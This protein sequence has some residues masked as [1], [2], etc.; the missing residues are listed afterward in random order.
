MQPTLVCVLDMDETI[1]TFQHDAFQI[2]PYANSLIALLRLLDVQLV[3]WSLG[4][5]EYVQ[6]IVN[7]HLPLVKEYAYKI[8]ARK[9][10]ERSRQRYD[11]CKASEHIRVMFESEIFLIAIDDKVSQNM[12]SQYDLR[13]N[14]LPYK[15]PDPRDR[16][17]L[18]VINKLILELVRLKQDLPAPSDDEAF[19]EHSWVC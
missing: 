6:R 10:C 2:R 11:F 14:V 3:L 15:K 1:G 4:S 13:I 8:F 17:L 19:V 18:D 12:D 16:A 5:D 9:E 7:G